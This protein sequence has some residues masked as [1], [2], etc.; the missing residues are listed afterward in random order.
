VTSPITY[1]IERSLSKGWR[2]VK[3]IDGMKRL[4]VGRDLCVRMADVSSYFEIRHAE[5]AYIGGGI[6]H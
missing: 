5:V 1:D 6:R 2:C 4:Y 3:G